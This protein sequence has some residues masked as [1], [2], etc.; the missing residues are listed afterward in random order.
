MA[1]GVNLESETESL[2]RQFIAQIIEGSQNQSD[3]RSQ[4]TLQTQLCR[5]QRKPNLRKVVTEVI[6]KKYTV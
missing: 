5:G 3:H 4:Q 1:L 6:A 2:Q